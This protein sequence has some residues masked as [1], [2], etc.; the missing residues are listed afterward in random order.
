VNARILIMAG[1][2]GGHVYPAIAVANCL[3]ARGAEVVWLGTRRGLEADVVPRAAIPMYTIAISGLRGKGVLSWVLA[4]FKIL[5]AVVQ[6]IAVILRFRPMAV[7]GMGGFVAGPGG[8]TAWLLHRPLLIHEQNA[9]AGLTNRLLVRL[10][11]KTLTAFP[12]V[13][14]SFARVVVTGN[15]VRGAISALPAPEQRYRERTGRIRLLVLGG[16]L[17]ARALNE[18]V[19]EALRRVPAVRRPDVWHQAGSRL[20]EAARQAYREAGVEARV[21]P[22]I[23]QMEQAYGWADLVVCRAGALTV[24]ELAAAGVA[25]VLVPY[26]YAVDD[27]QTSNASQLVACGAAIL[28]QQ[29][30]H[31]VERLVV[32]LTDLCAQ[33]GADTDP[34][35]RERLLQMAV[36]ARGEARPDAAERVAD[37]CLAEAAHA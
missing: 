33:G 22:Y 34:P 7:L 4:P 26:P 9:V 28:M 32:L 14:S 18:A 31:L 2:T 10:A 29:G 25:S 23:E 20:I 19:P 8:V 6:S 3:R 17:G 24:S 15:P 16:S 27:H 13:L 11:R 37:I 1:G 21:E 5:V 30:E 36:A 35:G 12:G